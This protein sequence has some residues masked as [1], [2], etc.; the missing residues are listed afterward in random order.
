MRENKVQFMT[1]AAMI[2]AIY[3]VL[4]IVFEPISYGAIQTRVAEA[5]TV[6]PFFTPAAVPGLFIGCLA[7]NLL[8]GGILLDVAFGSVATLIGAVGTYLLRKKSRYLAPLP[9][10]V[11]NVLIIPF[12]LRYGYGDPL[13]I[14]FLMGTV[15]LGEILSCGMMGTV[16]LVVLSRYKRV[17]FKAA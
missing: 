1:Q 15:G 7:A 14:P 5:L 12:V 13:P 10:I 16:L 17:L 8:G 9:P 6:L 2:A 11:A 3:V 4:C